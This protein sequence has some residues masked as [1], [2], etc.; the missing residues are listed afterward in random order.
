MSPSTAKDDQSD[1]ENDNEENNG[2]REKCATTKSW[3]TSI[4]KITR[5][6]EQDNL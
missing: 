4:L 1:S 5:M 3:N 6:A 2:Q